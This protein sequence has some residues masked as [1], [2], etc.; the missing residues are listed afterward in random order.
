MTLWK[1]LLQGIRLWKRSPALAA[2]VVLT[3]ALAIG[4]T[5]T[6]FTLTYSV[7]LRPFPF[8]EPERLVWITTDDTRAETPRPDEADRALNSNR[9]PLFAGWAGQLASFEHMAAW[10]AATRPDIY[11]VTAVGTRHPN[12]STACA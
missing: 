2:V 7:L 3:L 8:P 6:V 12:G 4:A 10:N 9:M 11:T 5:A 1:D